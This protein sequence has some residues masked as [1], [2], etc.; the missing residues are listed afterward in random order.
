MK[1]AGFKIRSRSLRGNVD[2]NLIEPSLMIRSEVV[3]YV[4]TWIEIHLHTYFRCRCSVVPYVGT[5]IEIYRGKYLHAKCYIVVPYV[6]PWIE[7]N[8]RMRCCRYGMSF[9]TWE[10]G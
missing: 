10:R 7:M 4:G 8:L 9:P 1:K 2:R 3:P 5:W 6:G